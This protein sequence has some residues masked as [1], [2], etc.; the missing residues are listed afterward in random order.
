MDFQPTPEDITGDAARVFDTSWHWRRAA[1]LLGGEVKDLSSSPGCTY[2]VGETGQAVL[3]GDGKWYPTPRAYIEKRLSTVVSGLPEAEKK[4]ICDMIIA[5][6]SA[7]EVRC[8]LCVVL[9]IPQSM[10]TISVGLPVHAVI[11]SYRC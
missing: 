5:L 2:L 9:F 8:R 1:E 7:E 11:H 4:D 10:Y 3:G 6:A